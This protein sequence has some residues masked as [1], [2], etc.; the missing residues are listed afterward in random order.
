MLYLILISGTREYKI[1][2]IENNNISKN[3]NKMNY[4][5]KEL[6]DR[7]ISIDYI[8]PIDIINI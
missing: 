4:V 3:E 6:K 8:Q 7:G 5:V 2:Q 1:V